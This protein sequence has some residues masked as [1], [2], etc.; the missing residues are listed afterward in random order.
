MGL[1]FAGKAFRKSL[2]TISIENGVMTY[3][4]QVLISIIIL[5]ISYSIYGGIE[6]MVI[7]D[8]SIISKATTLKY[9]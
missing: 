8:K 3:Y 2:K 1:V 5:K 6:N 7:F 4:I 9:L